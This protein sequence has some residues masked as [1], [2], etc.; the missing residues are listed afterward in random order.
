MRTV[1]IALSFHTQL[2]RF[3]GLKSCLFTGTVKL[4]SSALASSVVQIADRTIRKKAR[5]PCNWPALLPI[6]PLLFQQQWQLPCTKAW[7][8]SHTSVILLSP[9][10]YTM[11]T[12]TPAA[13]ADKPQGWVGQEENE[14]RSAIATD[15]SQLKAKSQQLQGEAS[16]AV[17]TDESALMQKDEELVTSM[18]ARILIC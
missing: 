3:I 18:C 9:E 8:G 1:T 6:D 12:N 4:P 17:A 11:A 13:A 2:P 7:V 10:G 5:K 15:E 16:Q 14:A